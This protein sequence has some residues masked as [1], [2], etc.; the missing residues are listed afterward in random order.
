MLRLLTRGILQ[1]QS[2]SNTGAMASLLCRSKAAA[3]DPVNHEGPCW[4]P[5]V[6]TG[7]AEAADRFE[8]LNR[9]ALP[10]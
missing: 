8:E 3:E 10:W 9:P 6:S 5:R 4:L 2:R 7:D 1:Y